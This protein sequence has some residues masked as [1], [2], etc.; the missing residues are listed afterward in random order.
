[1]LAVGALVAGEAPPEAPIHEALSG[2]LKEWPATAPAHASPAWTS[3]VEAYAKRQSA[4]RD[5]V[6]ECLACSKGGRA[7]GIVDPAPILDAIRK[8]VT[9]GQLGVVPPEAEG[10]RA[11]KDVA[12]LA[13]DVAVRLDAA[14]GDEKKLWLSVREEIARKLGG[15]DLKATI[16]SLQEAIKSAAEAG[17]LRGGGQ[18]VSARLEEW[19]TINSN[20]RLRDLER[21]AES[22]GPTVLYLLGKLDRAFLHDLQKLVSDATT[23]CEASLEAG[24]E[25]KRQLGRDADPDA[26]EAEVLS[27]VSDI[28]NTLRELGGDE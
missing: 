9:E 19:G 23:V 20:V 10:W 28:D 26:V 2:A 18:N 22:N 15:A 16:R 14:V 5:Q 4:V 13:K 24:E 21:L 1:L 6:A 12:E 8:G 11:W 27:L 17:V 3:L 25:R 7:G